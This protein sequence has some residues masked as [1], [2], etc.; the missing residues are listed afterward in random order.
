MASSSEEV[1]ESAVAGISEIARIIASLPIE[2]RASA[3]DVAERSYCRTAMNL[4]GTEDVTQ[5]WASA[6]MLRLRAEVEEQVVAN[7]RP[8]MALHEELVGL[9]IEAVTSESALA[10]SD[11]APAETVEEEIEEL[12]HKT[13][14]ADT[15]RDGLRN[16]AAS[17]VEIDQS[18]DQPVEASTNTP[19]K[20]EI[21]EPV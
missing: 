4:G 2:D 5:R 18:A 20:V 9:P 12:V 3:F 17:K 7:V 19:L 14:G 6:V 11:D 10:P 8:L 21:S 13:Y 1:L 15:L 16:E